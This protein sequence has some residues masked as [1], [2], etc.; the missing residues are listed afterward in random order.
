MVWRRRKSECTEPFPNCQLRCLS[1]SCPPR[2]FTSPDASDD[3]ELRAWRHLHNRLQRDA[4]IGDA[5]KV[6]PTQVKITKD[7]VHL[8]PQQWIASF[9]MDNQAD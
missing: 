4:P 1:H 5:H 3:A 9:D 7:E 8:K 2:D 6:F